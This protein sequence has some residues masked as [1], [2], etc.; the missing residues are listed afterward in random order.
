MELINQGI[1]VRSGISAVFNPVVLK[2]WQ[3]QNPL[4]NLLKQSAG[5]T[6]RAS[7]SVELGWGLRMCVSNK[8]SG[9]TD[10]ASEGLHLENHSFRVTFSCVWGEGTGPERG[11]SLS[12]TSQL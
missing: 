3:H 1:R 7:D 2:P 6:P 11:R 5:P 4:E 8:F 12:K 9:E 10:A